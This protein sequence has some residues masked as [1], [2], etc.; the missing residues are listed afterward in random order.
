MAERHQL[1]IIGSGPAG[2]SAG[3]RA[4]ARGLDYVVLERQDRFADTIQ[5]YQR[6]KFVMAT[7]D[8][9]PLH[10]DSAIAF[11]AGSREQVLGSWDQTITERE[12]RL[13]YGAEVA[14][15]RGQS[16]GFTIDAQGWQRDR[17][18]SGRA[19]DRRPGQ[20]AQAGRA[21][22]R[23]AAGAVPARR[24]GRVRGRDDR[25]DRRRRRR[26][27]ERAGA[28][29]AEPGHHCQPAVRVRPGQDRQ[30]ERDREGDR[31]R[32]DRVRLQRRAGADRTGGDSICARRKARARGAATGS[33]R[34]SAPTRHA[35]SSKPA[36]SPSRA[37]ARSTPRSASPTRPMS[38]GC[39][40]SARSPAIR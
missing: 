15:I 1:V 19:G 6:G 8:V 20:P 31:E 21:R 34:G 5:K 13:R 27:R 18:G 23:A 9:L 24:P 29:Q 12:I 38:R 37:A 10:G 22:R 2:L 16:G 33:S 35:A 26:D 4:A 25:G 32:P 39:T 30:P 17:G 7:P 40:R 36:A 11:A 28:R 3:A 14:E